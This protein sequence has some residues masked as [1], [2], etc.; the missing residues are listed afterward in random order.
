M[1]PATIDDVADTGTKHT[2]TANTTGKGLPSSGVTYTWQVNGNNIGTGSSIDYTFP[3]ANTTY[4]VSLE[5]KLAGGTIV[6]TETKDIA[7]GNIA[8]PTLTSTQVGN[9]PLKWEI[10]ADTSS[11]NIG[12]D[13]TK[14]WYIDNSNTAISG[15]TGNVLTYTFALTK[16][17]Y[18]VKFEATSPD[19]GVVR[20]NSIAV[21][22]GDATAPTLSQTAG[23]SDLNYNIDADLTDTGIT[24]SNWDY[25]W[26][27]NP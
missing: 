2:L 9:D 6:G 7:T 26:T 15:E 18:T 14:K 1:L 17:D 24:A 4:N 10:T 11:T 20:T 19:G 25:K 13:W 23:S 16:K 21:T 3:E 27:S 12:N 22:T 8:Q 5:T